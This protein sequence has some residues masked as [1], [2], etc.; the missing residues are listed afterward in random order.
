M[1][2]QEAICRLLSWICY[3]EFSNVSGKTIKE[4]HGIYVILIMFTFNLKFS[5]IMLYFHWPLWVEFSIGKQYLFSE[6]PTPFCTQEGEAWC[7]WQLSRYLF[8]QLL[9][10]WS[11]GGKLLMHKE[12]VEKVKA[13]RHSF[14]D[15]MNRH[16]VLVHYGQYKKKPW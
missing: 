11:K 7:C 16:T 14:Q 2:Q 1:S 8:A 10:S 12:G 6:I 9:S 5:P 3:R 4:V 13:Y 15:W